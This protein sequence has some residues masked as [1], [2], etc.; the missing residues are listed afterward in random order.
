MQT[1]RDM[2]TARE[3]GAGVEAAAAAAAALSAAGFG[4]SLRGPNS[5]MVM[6]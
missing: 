1:K 5:V 4:G 2:K 3:G 6:S